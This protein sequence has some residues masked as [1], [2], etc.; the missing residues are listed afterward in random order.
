[1]RCA[2]GGCTE[3]ND[4]VSDTAEEAQAQF[5][6]PSP[7]PDSCPNKPSNQPRLDPIHSYMVSTPKIHICIYGPL[8][9]LS[10]YLRSH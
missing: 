3:P 8:R 7:A 2:A 6:C 10:K 4:G 1:M 9:V 5:G